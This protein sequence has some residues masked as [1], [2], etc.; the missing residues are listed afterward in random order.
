MLVCAAR[1]QEE[2]QG[3]K[4]PYWEEEGERGVWGVQGLQAVGQ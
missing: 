2:V 3:E 4:M 1:V